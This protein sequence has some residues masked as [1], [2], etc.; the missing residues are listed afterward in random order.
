MELTVRAHGD[1]GNHDDAGTAQG[2]TR[3]PTMAWALRAAWLIP[4]SGPLAA[5]LRASAIRYGGLFEKLPA[6]RALTTHRRARW[7]ALRH[8]PGVAPEVAAARSACWACLLQPCPG[9]HIG[10]CPVDRLLLLVRAPHPSAQ[11]SPVQVTPSP[12]KPS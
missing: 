3:G 9:P 12:V 2:A 1:G 10:E 7:L 6:A 4:G 11:F 8:L 5:V